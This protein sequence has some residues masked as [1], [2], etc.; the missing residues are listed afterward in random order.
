M[1]LGS[2][3][4]SSSATFQG[5]SQYSKLA[6][7]LGLPGFLLY[8]WFVVAF[9]LAALLGV[10]AS[11]GAERIVSTVGFGIVALAPIWAVFTFAPDYPV[12]AILIH[13]L[14]G[15]AVSRFSSGS[16]GSGPERA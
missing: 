8:V 15:Y 12:F 14:G 10:I 5:E 16:I 11:R 7:E 6:W 2:E 13:L 1:T 4:A 9:A 3:Y